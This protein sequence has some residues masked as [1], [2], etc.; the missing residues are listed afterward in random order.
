[1][2][3]M[4]MAGH[5]HDAAKPKFK[6]IDKADPFFP[7]S[8]VGDRYQEDCWAMQP[9]VLLQ[10]YD[11]D[12]DKTFRGCDRAPQQWRTVCYAGTGTEVSGFSLREYSLAIGYCLKGDPKYQPWC[13]RGVVKNF[14]DV[15]AKYEDGLR[16]CKTVPGK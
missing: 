7:C 16:F 9:A 14:I 6:M 15:T 1:M 12:F 8:V 5:D 13:F 11:G 4:D 10:L 2:E 3:G